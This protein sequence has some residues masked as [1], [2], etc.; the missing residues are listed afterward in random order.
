MNTCCPSE[1]LEFWYLL[2]KYACMMIPPVKTLG[3]ESL[4]R[5]PIDSI[6]PVLSQFVAGGI[7]SCVTPLGEDP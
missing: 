2:G 4:T 5:F 3:I 6:S 7:E 1:S